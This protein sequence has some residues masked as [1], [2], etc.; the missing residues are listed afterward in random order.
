MESEE[1]VSTLPATAPTQKKKK[2]TAN[3][4]PQQSRTC[5]FVQTLACKK[6][7]TYR[8]CSNISPDIAR[9]VFA[10]LDT[11]NKL[12]IIIKCMTKVQI[13][14]FF[15]HGVIDQSDREY[16]LLHPCKTPFVAR[17]S[18]KTCILLQGRQKAAILIQLGG[19]SAESDA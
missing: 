13:N 10:Y 18:R 4:H 3:A 17:V 16:L 7:I 19:V 6:Q 8:L 11:D 1:D 9:H 5:D 2:S 12:Y 14:T 15:E